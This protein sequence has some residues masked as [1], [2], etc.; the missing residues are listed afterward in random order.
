ME[1]KITIKNSKEVIRA[2]GELA[3]LG[4][5]VLKDGEISLTDSQYLP[6]LA[7][8]YPIL[9]AGI[10]DIDEVL[11]EIKNL[12]Q[13]EILELV[14]EMYLAVNRFAEGKK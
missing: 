10:S 9:E 5:Q 6:A 1:Q 4:G 13:V 11:K 2:L 7:L 14:K 3:F 8:K 12:D